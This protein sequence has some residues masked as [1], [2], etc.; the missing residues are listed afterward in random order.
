MRHFNYL[1]FDL[2][3]IIVDWDGI[4]PL[5][6][7]TGGRLSAEDARRFWLESEWVRAFEAGRCGADEYARG[8]VA[9][10]S[11]EIEPRKFLELFATWDRGTLPGS[12]ELLR[13]LAP[14]YPL[15]CLS[16][17]NPIHWEM[18]RKA[19]V[20][21]PFQ[22]LFASFETGF[23]KP[24]RESFQHVVD[25]LNVAP[26]TILF[27]DD[28]RECTDAAGKLGIVARLTKGP[29]AVSAALAELG[30]NPDLTID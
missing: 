20:L 23:V 8:V 6:E 29:V 12:M 11:L 18:H 5:V 19:G 13:G 1:L 24:D 27:F 3:G 21:E 16:N 14:K 10:L 2:G 7:L 22:R 9:E 15:A 17:N 25:Q 30:I 4:R 26:E 28:N